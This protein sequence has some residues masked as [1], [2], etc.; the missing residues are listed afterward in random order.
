MTEPK[1]R[2][3]ISPEM[4]AFVGAGVLPDG[5]WPRGA[6][7]LGFG[8]GDAPVLKYA[9]HAP[10]HGESGVLDVILAVG[11]DACQRLFGTVPQGPAS[12]YLPSALRD[13]VHSILDCRARPEAQ[14]VLRGARCIDLLCRAF[15]EIADNRLVPMDGCP[16]LNELDAARIAAA[17]RLIDERWQEKLTLGS[18][19][20]ACGINRDKLSR[21][22]RSIYNST[23]ADALSE[24]RLSGARRL[25]LATDLPV[26]TIGYRCGYLNNASFTRAFSRKY[27]VSPSKLRLGA[28]A[29]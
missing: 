26:A 8:N 23:V 7:F 20:R 28:I 25:L 11:R 3:D 24:Q 21:G 9:D 29:A 1:Q 14:R 2:V 19:A 10:E 22:F 12:W 16:V 6:V 27:G 18:I 4:I 15:D 13:L 5:D 17:R